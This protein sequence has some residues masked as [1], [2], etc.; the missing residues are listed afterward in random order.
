MYEH[1]QESEDDGAPDLKREHCQSQINS[2]T[3]GAVGSLISTF[4]LDA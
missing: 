4:G 2:V 1:E 3:E